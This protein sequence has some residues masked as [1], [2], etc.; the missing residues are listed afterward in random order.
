V[1]DEV[2]VRDVKADELSACESL[3]ISV[4]GLRP[5]DGSIN[6]RLLAALQANS[7]V[8]LGAYAG[9]ELIGFAYSFL[10]RE[11]AGA[12]RGSNARLYQYSQ[13]AVVSPQWQSKGVGRKLKYAQRAR[14]LADGITVMRWAFDPVKTRNAYFNLNVLGGRVVKLI[15]SMY[16]DAGFGGDTG[17]RTDR[18]IVEWDLGAVTDTGGDRRI[19][20]SPTR[21]AEDQ[22]GRLTLGES[23]HGIDE[24][25]VAIPAQWVR[26]RAEHGPTAAAELRG[27]LR[28]QFTKAL[29]AGRVG[30]SCDVVDPET[31]LY[32][33]VPDDRSMLSAERKADEC[34]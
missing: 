21:R 11:G 27:K 12:A 25:T 34:H 7:G 32:R 4:M 33:F 8:V 14:C 15:P 18:F 6:P 29:D 26:Y 24:V 16:G 22:V 2:I 3:Y 10:G 30:V 19:E 1:Q 20:R 17:D 31:A 9:G 28:D 23:R 5:N 13:L